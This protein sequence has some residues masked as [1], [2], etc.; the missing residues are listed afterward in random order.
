[1]T[2]MRKLCRNQGGQMMA[3][4]DLMIIVPL[5][6]F[7]VLL[8]MN[9]GMAFYLKEKL[10]FVAQQAARHA[11]G[12]PDNEMEE[13]ASSFAK[14]LMRKMNLDS[15][16]TKVETAST[17]VSGE[18]AVEVKISSWMSTFGNIDWLPKTVSVSDSAV[19]VASD[20]AGAYGYLRLVKGAASAPGAVYLPI[21][22]PKTKGGVS[23][24]LPGGVATTSVAK[25]VDELKIWNPLGAAT[26]SSYWP[27]TQGPVPIFSPFSSPTM[28]GGNT[29]VNPGQNTTPTLK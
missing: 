18:P 14:E 15:S 16:A 20:T 21:V 6:V 23:T 2:T 19:A 3:A 28:G 10:A 11:A 27:Y 9:T 5:T 29:W 4:V 24:P 13:Q 26:G 25:P 7:A 12:F 22:R 1:M 8:L 17:T